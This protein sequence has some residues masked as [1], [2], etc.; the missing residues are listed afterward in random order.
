VALA[1]TPAASSGYGGDHRANRIAIHRGPQIEK[2][3]TFQLAAEQSANPSAS[4]TEL[5]ASPGFAREDEGISEHGADS[6][7]LYV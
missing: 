7:R 5:V 1:T 3:F 6:R 4:D 2:C